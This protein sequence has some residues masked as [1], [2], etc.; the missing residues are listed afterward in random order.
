MSTKKGR[1]G[2]S[3]SDFLSEEGKLEETE[4]TAIKR[5]IAWQLKEAMQSNKISKNKMATDMATSRSQLDRILDPEN[6]K[7]QLDTLIKAAKY[8]GHGLRVELV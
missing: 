6:P 2:S 3:F 7:V 5:V 8:L 1:I 4:A